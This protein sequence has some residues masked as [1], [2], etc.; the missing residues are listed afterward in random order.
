MSRFGSQR[1]GNSGALFLGASGISLTPKY[2]GA[3]IHHD[4]D[5]MCCHHVNRQ[6]HEITPRKAANRRASPSRYA[7]SPIVPTRCTGSAHIQSTQRSAA[8]RPG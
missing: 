2:R 5:A 7:S 4:M 1:K 3:A 6:L 8:P